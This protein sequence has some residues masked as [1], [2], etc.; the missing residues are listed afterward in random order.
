MAAVGSVDGAVRRR[1]V[2]PAR[3]H[4]TCTDDPEREPD[5]QD[6]QRRRPTRDRAS[7]G[8]PTMLRRRNTP[9]N[10]AMTSDTTA[11]GAEHQQLPPRHALGLHRLPEN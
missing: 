6:D 9:A 7:L 4:S 2:S 1:W 5:P 10:A 8:G 3:R 11:G